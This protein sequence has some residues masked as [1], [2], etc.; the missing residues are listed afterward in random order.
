M[1][2]LVPTGNPGKIWV[3]FSDFEQNYVKLPSNVVR[4]GWEEHSLLWSH[5]MEGD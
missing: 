3:S 2:E 5:S 4:N 1:V